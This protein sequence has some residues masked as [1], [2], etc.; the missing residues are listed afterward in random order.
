[1]SP[2]SRTSSLQRG[3]SMLE[4]M[5]V[6]VI[7]AGMS[8]LINE[9]LMTTQHTDG[10]LRAA[11]EASQRGQKLTFEVTSLV[12]ESRHLYEDDAQ[13]QGYVAACDLSRFPLAPGARLPIIDAD[14]DMRID[15]P[16]ELRAGNML[17]F[18]RE[19]NASACVAD[20]RK[21]RMRWIDTYRM[22]AVYP[23]VVQRRL[24]NDRA[25]SRDLVVWRSVPFAS[26]P[27]LMEIGDEDERTSVVKD[28]ANR[29]GITHAWDPSATVEAAFHA[30]SGSGGLSE[31]PDLDFQLDEDELLSEGGRLVYAGVQLAP[32]D[33]GYKRARAVLAAETVDA[34]VPNGFEVKIGGPSGSRKVWIHTVVEAASRNGKQSAIQDYTTTAHVRDF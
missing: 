15:E 4:I 8:L 7:L 18:V 33:A 9:A 22:V 2:A 10:L 24:R 30:M 14:P 32:T 20:R 1:M 26:Y 29:Y 21:A 31:L 34:W 23:T 13:G 11:A 12:S 27:Q 17:L 19:I 25:Q 28:L 6:V 16:T 5:I 3:Y